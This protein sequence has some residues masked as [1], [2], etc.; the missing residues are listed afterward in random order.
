MMEITFPCL[1]AWLTVYMTLLW[2][3][4]RPLQNDSLVDFGW[5]S[6]VA[7]LGLYFWSTHVG[8]SLRAAVIAAMYGFAGLRM[9]I[10]YTVRTISLG[11]DR[12]FGLWKEK[13][14]RGDGLFSIRNPD[15]NFFVFYQVQNIANIAFVAM[16]IRILSR[17]PTPEV[18]AWQL[19][20]AL[21]WCLAVIGQNTADL[22]L[23]L[24]R[25][26]HR[27]STE[28]LRSGLW[29][30]SRHPNYF[31]EFLMWTSYTAAA[32]PLAESWLEIATLIAIP[33][34]IYWFLVYFTGIPMTEAASLAKRGE[35][36]R[37]YQ[38][39]VPRFFPS[40]RRIKR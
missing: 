30:L 15:L 35:I 13:W 14:A 12:R 3:L 11:K 19:T 40:F 8:W 25:I 27:E 1:A 39:E 26:R 18:N 31:C 5:P 10:G 17:D 24:F 29:S 4:R 28:V 34:A 23:Y 7:I 32:L 2:A 33:P 9:T 20:W 6:G 16:P 38:A 21:V 36:Y 22:Q 37:R